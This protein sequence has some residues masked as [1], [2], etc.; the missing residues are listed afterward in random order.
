MLH[1][2]IVIDLLKYVRVSGARARERMCMCL[3]ASQALTEWS[4]LQ[5]GMHMCVCVFSILS[6]IRSI[7]YVC[8]I[9]NG[10][11]YVYVCEARETRD[12]SS[13]AQHFLA[14]RMDPN[15]AAEHEP[16]PRVVTVWFPL[17]VDTYFLRQSLTLSL[18]LSLSLGGDGSI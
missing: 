11:I 18:P 15:A 2:Q 16:T 6:C 3:Y 1:P 14:P 10:I 4:S 17:H 9:L 8:F 12:T 5:P 7:R 13:H